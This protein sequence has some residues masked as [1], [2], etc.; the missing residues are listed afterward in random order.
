ML[1]DYLIVGI[2]MYIV[3]VILDVS[4]GTVHKAVIGGTSFQV[5]SPEGV[6]LA[7]AWIIELCILCLYF[8]IL[9]GIRRGQTPGNHAPHIAVRDISTGKVIGVWRGVVRSLIRLALYAMLFIPGL[10]NDLFPLWDK[11]RQS[12]ADKVVHSVV[13][14]LS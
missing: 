9:N 1:L 5:R 2:L 12:L 6:D 7:I 13:V 8:G 11:R 10:L 3:L 4:I 14:Q